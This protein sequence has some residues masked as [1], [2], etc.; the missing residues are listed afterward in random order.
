MKK[1]IGVL[2]I[3][4]GTSAFAEWP[5]PDSQNCPE[6]GTQSFIVGT[7]THGQKAVIC[8]YSHDTNKVDSKGQVIKH[9]FKVKF[10]N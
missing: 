4:A 9:T 2:V 3:L 1:L 5:Y 10:D 6:D 8:T 7:C